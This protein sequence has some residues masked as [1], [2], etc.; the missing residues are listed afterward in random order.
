MKAAGILYA[1][2]KCLVCTDEIFAGD[3]YIIIP[4]FLI[5]IP[6]EDIKIMFANGLT[7][8][9]CVCKYLCIVFGSA[10]L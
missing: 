9:Q 1:Y 10:G 8:R 2:I 7:I 3:G 6:C 5:F 4:K